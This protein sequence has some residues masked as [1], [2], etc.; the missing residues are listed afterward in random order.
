MKTIAIGVLL[1]IPSIL[2]DSCSYGSGG[3]LGVDKSIQIAGSD[4]RI[5]LHADATYQISL[6]GVQ[7]SRR[8]PQRNEIR[9]KK[10]VFDPLVTV[11]TA[12][13]HLRH[14]T[15]TSLGKRAYI[16]QFYT[17][18]LAQYQERLTSLGAEVGVPLPDQALIVLMNPYVK[19]NVERLEFVRWVGLYEPMYR[20]EDGLEEVLEQKPRN[21]QKYNIMVLKNGMQDTI[22]NQITERGGKVHCLGP[23]RV[24]SASMDVELLAVLSKNPQVLY[25]ELWTDTGHD[26]DDIRD[27]Q[28][29]NF[30]ETVAGYS[31]QGV[32]G[33][34]F[35][36][37]LRDTHQ[38]FQKNPPLFHT[39]NNPSDFNHGTPVYGIVFGNGTGDPTARGLL[40]DAEQPLFASRYIELKEYGGRTDRYT[41]ASELVNPKGPHRGVFQT[42]SWGHTQTTSYTTVSAEIDQILFELD[43]LYT[44]SQSNEGTRRS[45]PEAWAKNAVSIGGIHNG[46][47]DRDRS[48]DYWKSASIGP[49]EDGRIKPDLSNQHGTIWT[50]D[51]TGDSRYANF[52]GTSGATPAT[53]G[54]FGLLFQMWADGIFDGGPGK[55]RDVFDF[56]PH[57]TTAKALM[58][59]SAYRYAFSGT[60]HNLTRTHQGWGVPDI[61][62]L[63]ETAQTHGWRFPILINESAV[64]EP[65]QVHTYTIITHGDQPLRATLVYADPPGVPSAAQHRINDLTLKA[66]S[67]SGVVYWGNHGLLEGNWSRPAGN[68]N[69]IDTVENI[70]IQNPESGS[71]RIQVLGDEI[72]QDG[73]IE[74]P[75]LD[76]DYALVVS[77]GDP[78]T[79][80][81]PEPPAE[82][83]AEAG[84]RMIR[85]DWADNSEPDLSGYKV[86]RGLAPGGPYT[87]IA[88]VIQ[89][90]HT[91]NGLNNDTSY[92]YYVTA[93]NSSQE[94]SKASPTVHAVPY[95]P[96]AKIPYSTGFESGTLDKHWKTHSDTQF[97]RVLLTTNHGPKSGA[98]HLTMDDGSKGTYSINQARL[99]LDLSNQAQVDLTF[100]WK[101]FNDESHAEDGVFISDNGGNTFTKVYSL[102]AGN[103][104]WKEIALDLDQLAHE[105]GLKLN[106]TFVV[107][108]QQTDNYGIN[109]DGMAFDDLSVTVPQPAPEHYAKLPYST[110][111]ESGSLD[112]YWSTKSSTAF[113]RIQVTPSF[114]PKSGTYHLTMDDGSKGTYSINEAWLR[115]DLSDHTQAQL[116]FWWKEFNDENHAEDGVFISNNGGATFFKVY[117]LVGAGSTWTEISLDLQQLASQFDLEFTHTFVVKFQQT[118]N[119]GINTDGM[120]FDDITVQ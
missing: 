32:R 28:G 84:D 114:T 60:E 95:N 29:A 94:E 74:T 3:G 70:F 113:G 7:F 26:I 92:Y 51:D 112:S 17:Q 103:S 21:L 90:T 63:Y 62:T 48:N 87:T 40:P 42:S 27:L 55:G 56:R 53:A 22:A 1:L 57:F 23:T 65:L 86:Y 8:F 31:G 6:D 106:A 98:Y 10:A 91:D 97:G 89:S 107:Q 117:N 79:S 73:H 11:P 101:E 24:L 34:V 80:N 61:K 85:L 108:F 59:H 20:L 109:T 12:P 36:D 77:G 4:V 104:S 82:L 44:Q 111:F 119:Y 67:P 14:A 78:D 96:Y 81:P 118:D 88:N 72:V 46:S 37:G 35:D 64:L 69:T 50:T 15:Q 47:D 100:W 16:V 116:K 68:P 58:I 19:Q 49:A 54:M 39:K 75:S 5:I 18:A 93:L 13:V 45:R 102:T 41:Q 2:F 83:A 52:G 99:Y 9:L 66:I 38:D 43:L 30:V 115:L 71:W 110:G 25:I 33:Q 76:A 105:N 120:A